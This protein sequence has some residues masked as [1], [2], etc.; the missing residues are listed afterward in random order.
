MVVAAHGLGEDPKQWCKWCRELVGDRPVI[1]C[2]RGS[3]TGRTPS[4][5]MSYAH[6]SPRATRQEAIQ[7]LQ[8]LL[9]R[10]PD[11][12]DATDA[13]FIGFSLGA[14][15]GAQVVLDEPA[16]FPRAVLIEGGNEIWDRKTAPRF[17]AAGGR[18]IL[19]AC[20]TEGCRRWAEF[21]RRRLDKAGVA[22]KVAVGDGGGHS[23]R[24]GPVSQAVRG[25]F[26]WVIE[27]D[28]RWGR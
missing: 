14:N 21:S 27:D 1:L 22:V 15:T 23:Y 13:L 26:R 4:G 25:A 6:T 28:A 10:H 24:E 16:A 20:G 19:F 3:A 2:L 8:A 9:A 7:G 17:R 5:S 12:V 18:R 11:R